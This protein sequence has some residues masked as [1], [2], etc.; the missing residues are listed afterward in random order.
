MFENDS[1]RS[2]LLLSISKKYLGI[3]LKAACLPSLPKTQILPRIQK[4]T[5]SVT[6]LNHTLGSP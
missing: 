3:K 4:E 1:S 6:H 5:L 2:T